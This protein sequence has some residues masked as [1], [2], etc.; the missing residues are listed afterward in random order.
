MSV[1]AQIKN[2]F[3][4]NPVESTLETSGELSLGMPD[5]SN[6]SSTMG[7]ASCGSTWLIG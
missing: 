6:P 7:A 3:A 1:V 4:K 2:L 5:A